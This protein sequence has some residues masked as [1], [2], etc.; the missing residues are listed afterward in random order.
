M[1]VLL[2]L[3]AP[4]SLLTFVGPRARIQMEAS[5]FYALILKSDKLIHASQPDLLSYLGPS[6]LLQEVI[7]VEAGPRQSLNLGTDTVKLPQRAWVDSFPSHIP[8]FSNSR[9]SGSS[10]YLLKLSHSNPGG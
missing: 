5:F 1:N 7:R 10:K 3:K 2:S 8:Y 4:D 9:F 6:Q